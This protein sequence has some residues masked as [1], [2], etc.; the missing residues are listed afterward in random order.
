MTST[1]AAGRSATA[2]PARGAMDMRLEVV[3]LL[4]PEGLLPERRTARRGR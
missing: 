4:R 1:D 3:V 2:D